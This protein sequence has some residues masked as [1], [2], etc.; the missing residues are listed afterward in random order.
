MLSLWSFLIAPLSRDVAEI[1]GRDPIGRVEHKSDI[2]EIRADVARDIEVA[3]LRA[4][5]ARCEAE[6]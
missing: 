2:R 5:Q 1:Q 4:A 3:I 6:R